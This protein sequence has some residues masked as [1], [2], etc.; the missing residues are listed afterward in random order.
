VK[1]TW[2]VR[3]SEQFKAELLAFFKQVPTTVESEADATTGLEMSTEDTRAYNAFIQEILDK[4]FDPTLEQIVPVDDEPYGAVR[5]KSNPPWLG[6]FRLTGS[7][8]FGIRFFHQS[9]INGK[10]LKQL[11][12]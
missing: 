4:D 1:K 6:F 3:L 7:V 10:S 2:S 11:L 9:Q 12:R 8:A 5:A